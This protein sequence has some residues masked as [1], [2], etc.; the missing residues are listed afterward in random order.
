MDGMERVEWY[1]IRLQCQVWYGE[2]Y[3]SKSEENYLCISELAGVWMV[4]INST[5]KTWEILNGDN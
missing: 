2:P 4:K 3:R 5:D 1:K